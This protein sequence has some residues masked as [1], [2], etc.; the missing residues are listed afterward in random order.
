MFVYTI[1]LNTQ[2]FKILFLYFC[3]RSNLYFRTAFLMLHEIFPVFVLEGTAPVLK[4]KTIAKRNDIRSGTDERKTARKGGRTRFNRILAEC[5]EMLRYMGL[6][7]VKG[8]GEAEAMCAYL[9]EDGVRDALNLK[10]RKLGG[11]TYVSVRKI[12]LL[13]SLIDKSK[14]MTIL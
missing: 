9:N 13:K 7:C 5:E 3:H 11:C 4:H 10:M 8:Y 1:S 6:G 2:F 14:R 12:M